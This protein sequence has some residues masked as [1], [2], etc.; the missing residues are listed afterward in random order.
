MTTLFALCLGKRYLSLAP[1]V[2]QAH[3]GNVMLKGQATVETGNAAANKIRSMLGLPE[4]KEGYTLTVHGRHNEHTM[5][6]NR[7]F[8]DKPMNSLFCL[9]DEGFTEK[10]GAITLYLQLDVVNTALRYELHQLC[11]FNIPL[12]R[13]VCPKILI[14]GQHM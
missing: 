9:T 13:F 2:R 8:D 10:L 5:H 6:W 11:I 14:S 12:P 1:V 3:E 4:A 7:C